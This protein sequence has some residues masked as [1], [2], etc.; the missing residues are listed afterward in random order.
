MHPA[1]GEPEELEREADDRGPATG[2]GKDHGA[3]PGAGRGGEQEREVD[4]LDVAGD[5]EELL[6]EG[7]GEGGGGGAGGVRRGREV[8]EVRRG[9]EVGGLRF[10]EIGGR[11]GGWGL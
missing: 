6:G 3:G 5:E 10:R 2:V 11:G 8:G 7:G 1:H 4:E 9:R